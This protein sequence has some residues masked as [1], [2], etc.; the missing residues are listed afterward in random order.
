MN[1]VEKL[2][3]KELKR[4]QEKLALIPSENYTTKEVLE[5]VG[6]VLSNKYSEGYSKKRYYHGNEFVDEIELLAI[7]RAKKLF[8]V[9][10]AN[11]QPYSGSPANTAV[12]FALLKPGDKILGM[13]LAAGGHLT[14]GHPKVTISGK[15]FKSIQYTTDSKGRL[16]YDEI[17]RLA[18]KHKPKVIISGA[19]A[20]PRKVNFKKFGEI[21]DAV[22]AI[23][24]ADISHIAGLVAAGVHQS[25]ARYAHIITTT[26]HKTLRGPRGAMIMVTNKGLKADEDLGVNIDRAVFPGLQ[27]GPHNNTTAG[28][29]IALEQAQKK[30]FS[31]HAQQIVKNAH[32][33]AQELKAQG[34]KLVSGG[35]D[36]HLILID[37]TNKGVDG[38]QAAW[39]LDH[40]GIITNRNSIPHDKKSPFYPSGL[41]IGTPAITTRGMKEKDMKKIAEWMNLATKV[42]LEI[43]KNTKGRKQYKLAAAK[44]KKLKVIAAEVR[45]FCKKHPIY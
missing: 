31:R 44:D 12:Y 36:N 45:A 19:T 42:A 28:I 43:S 6:S 9:P 33:L 15:Y 35:T 32:A 13:G 27:G 17:T 22:G 29:A 41:R 18:K 23:H 37:L 8:G 26:T 10:H 5:A 39:A 38:W 4:Q 20:Y 2:I 7:E 14:H 1:K 3:N 11:V 16:D 21:A 34:F 24:V 30:S 25:P 40:A